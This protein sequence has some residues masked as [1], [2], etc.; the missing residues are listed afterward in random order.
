HVLE[1]LAQPFRIGTLD[2]SISA[3]IGISHYPQHGTDVDAL[4]HAADLAMYQTKQTGRNDFHTFSSALYARAS[5]ASSIEGR[6]K[7]ALE[8]GG[9]V[10]HYQPVVDMHSGE[11]AGAE[12]LLRLPGEN[13]NFIPPERF[14][15]IA[16]SAGLIGALGEWVAGE[17]C[18]QH[19]A[20]CGEGLPPVTI[21]INVSTL[22]FR[23]RGFAQR[24][25]SIVRESGIAA[26]YLQVEV[27]EST[28]MENVDDAIRTLERVRE[29][30]IRVALDDF[31][32][33]LS[34]LS[35]LSNL[36][37]DKLKV[38]QSFVQRLQSDRASRAITGAVIALGRTLN[39]QI[40]GEGIE[41]PD[42]LAYL[43]QHGCD[44]AQGFLISHP[45]PP[46]E[47]AQWCRERP[48]LQYFH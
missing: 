33:G 9:L 22:Q 47:F 36:P 24:L 39:L 26:H 30:G 46:A 21:A 15:P 5:D 43:Q 17:A 28:V 37:L 45:L 11:V 10:L 16:E 19:A 41:S 23:Q 31:G 7:Q 48:G 32:T 35:H 27:T 1:A 34:S 2:L 12:A 20:W 18:R 3:S 38:D 29:C 8:S 13:G 44:Q 42:A 25:K 6:L 4:I 14:V 40:V